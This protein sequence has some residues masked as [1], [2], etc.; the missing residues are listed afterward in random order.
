MEEGLAGALSKGEAIFEDVK[1]CGFCDGVWE[2][3]GLRTGFLD[4]Y[5]DWLCN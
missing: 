4:F 1:R 3:R 2:R 5:G